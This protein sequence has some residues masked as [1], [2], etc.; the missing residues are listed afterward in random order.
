[1]VAGSLFG[2]QPNEDSKRKVRA[3]LDQLKGK[4]LVDKDILTDDYAEYTVY[5]PI[6]KAQG[7]GSEGPEGPM[8]DL[9]P[10]PGSRTARP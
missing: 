3:T 6:L 2:G 4:R 5:W 1:M 8:Y 9:H 10:I 7:E